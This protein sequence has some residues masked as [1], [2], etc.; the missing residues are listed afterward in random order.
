MYTNIINNIIELE[1]VETF[2][3]IKPY[4]VF[5]YPKSEDASNV[6]IVDGLP[7]YQSKKENLALPLLTCVWNPIALN[8]IVV[9]NDMLS[10]YRIFIGYV[11]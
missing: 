5:L 4:Y 7:T 9:T 3:D 6:I 8:N 2:I 11:Q 1:K 10:N